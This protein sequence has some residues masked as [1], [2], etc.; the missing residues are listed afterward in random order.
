MCLICLYAFGVRRFDSAGLLS[1]EQDRAGGEP[2][3]LLDVVQN[4]DADGI[5]YTV[6]FIEG[7]DA[8]V[9]DFEAAGAEVVDFRAAGKFDTRALWR[10][11]VFSRKRKFDALHAH[12]PYARALGRLCARVG[13]VDAIVSAQHNVPGNNH[14]I[15]RIPTREKRG[16]GV[17]ID[18]WFR[19]ELRGFARERLGALGARQSFDAT[20]LDGLFDDHVAGRADNGYR[21]WDLVMLET[22]HERFID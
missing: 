22:W 9:S 19:E 3:P 21:I 8:L 17:P 10:R 5:S 2:R 4:T 20:G 11:A 13:D 15:L 14:P 12:P 1:D 16:F 7:D 6:C 18:E